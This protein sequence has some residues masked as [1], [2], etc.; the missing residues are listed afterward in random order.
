MENL[1]SWELNVVDVL[2][3]GSVNLKIR[4]A[5]PLHLAINSVSVL[6]NV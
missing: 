2:I 5:T 4:P 3:L 6:P 1:A